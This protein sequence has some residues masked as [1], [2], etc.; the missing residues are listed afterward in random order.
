MKGEAVLAEEQSIRRLLGSRVGAERWAFLA[1]LLLLA[2]LVGLGHAVEAAILSGLVFALFLFRRGEPA[3][4]EPADAV[5]AT[6]ADA[7]EIVEVRPRRRSPGRC[8]MRW[9]CRCC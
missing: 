6:E 5:V 1:A 7:A 9:K 4:D 2:V 8:S 3:R